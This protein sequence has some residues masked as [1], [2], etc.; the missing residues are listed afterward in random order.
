MKINWCP[1]DLEDE[2]V[3]L[4][5]LEKADFGRLFAAASDPL[6][7]AQHPQP[8]RYKEEVFRS[9]FDGAIASGTAFLISET[10]SG[11]VM[12]STRFYDYQPEGASVAIGYTFLA[13][14]YWGGQYN[15]RVKKLLLAYAF[16]YV[17]KVLFHI[18]MENIRSQTAATRLGAKF[19]CEIEFGG[20]GQEKPYFQYGIEKAD[21]LNR[22]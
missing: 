13:R 1:T 3:K 8:D 9:F 22:G 10:A 20:P 16:Q 14:E 6:I 17:E 2:V 12:G 15:M 21:W 19:D 18:G 7:W 4:V 11:E 5:P